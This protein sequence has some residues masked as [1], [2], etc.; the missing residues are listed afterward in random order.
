MSSLPTTTK[1]VIIKSPGIAAVESVPLPSLRPEYILHVEFPI[2]AHPGI[3]VGCDYVGNVVKIGSK[4]TK[5]FE[6]GDRIAGFAHGSNQSQHE[7]G[8]WGEY[9]VVKGD[10]QIKVPDGVPDEEAATWGITVSTVAQGLY[11]TLE[12]PLPSTVTPSSSTPRGT[13]FIYGGSTA[14]GIGGIAFAKASNYRVITTSSPRNFSYLKSIGADEVL[15]YRSA[16]LGADV[17]ALAGGKLARA[18]DCVSEGPSPPACAAALS[19]AEP[20]CRMA[21][22]LPGAD[23]AGIREANPQRGGGRGGRGAADFPASE[24]ED[25]AYGKMFW[26][27][28]ARPLLEAGKVR[29]ATP[30]V[31]RD[32]KKG[33]EG[34][35]HGMRELKE[36]R[37]S[38][39]KLV[40]TLP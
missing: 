18:W 39:G 28:E 31:N 40:Y 29:L 20:D 10:V 17:R 16:T 25:H 30:I 24:E 4:V 22:L 5:D 23:G 9:I 11:Q 7:D 21:A 8:A 33:L 35:I 34:A 6:I 32:G 3:R 27:R 2:L 13:I 12:L 26:E 36:G 1:A 37:V 14:T 19:P 38:A 15:D